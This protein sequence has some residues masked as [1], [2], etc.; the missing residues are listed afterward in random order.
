MNPSTQKQPLITVADAAEIMEAGSC[1]YGTIRIPAGIVLLGRTLQEP[2]RADRDFPPFDRAMMDGY[3]VDA[4]SLDPSGECIV[5]VAG[6]LAAG[7]I[8]EEYIAPGTAM[9]INTGAPMP[10]FGGN[11]VIPHEATGPLPG[12]R[13]RIAGCVSRGQFVHRRGSDALAGD[14]LVRPGMRIDG[15]VLA[16][17]ATVGLT[18]LVVNRLPTITV[19][20]TGKELVP[21]GAT[22]LPH[23]IRAS[24]GPLIAALLKERGLESTLA[25]VDDDPSRVRA[26]VESALAD[27][28]VV[29][30]T[31]AVSKGD[32]DNLPAIFAELGVTCRFHGVRQKP[33]K[34]L[35]YGEDDTGKRIFALPGNPVSTYVCLLRHVLPTIAGTRATLP[36][37]PLVALARKTNNP[38]P[39]TRF[40]PVRTDSCTRTGKTL[41]TPVEINTSGDFISTL[42][43]AGFTEAPP[44]STL[45][46]GAL[47]SLYQA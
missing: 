40:L 11:A 23:Q 26:A 9:R 37:L 27:A 31:G 28:D 12:D 29:I 30:T 44:E 17:A 3:A 2:V 1:D 5:R 7:D 39:L 21:V 8:S 36:P 14:I 43:C 47:L 10:P 18:S 34:P 45:P 4:G 35:W 22:P 25:L 16:I 32:H 13:I 38:L 15:N 24:N 6:N 42:G 41:A 46:A 20:A 19:L 33:G